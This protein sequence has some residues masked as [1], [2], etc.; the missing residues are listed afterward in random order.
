MSEKP[1]TTMMGHVSHSWDNM[2][3]GGNGLQ[4]LAALGLISFSGKGE[5]RLLVPLTA[6]EARRASSPIG[7]RPR[8]DRKVV[9][10]IGLARMQHS[11]QALRHTLGKHEAS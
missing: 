1:L 11:P 4:L 3:V 7:S 9:L 2:S 5:P 10:A 6:V 8:S